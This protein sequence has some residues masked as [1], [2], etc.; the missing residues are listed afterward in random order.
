[1]KTSAALHPAIEPLESRIA[2]ATFLV[3]SLA[4]GTPTKDGLLT[5]REAIL[6]ATTNLPSGDAKAGGF[7]LDTITFSPSLRGGEIQ[8]LSSLLIDG[9]GRLN[10]VGPGLTDESITLRGDGAQRVMEITAATTGVAL[11]HLAIT[12]GLAASGGGILTNAE[13]LL[14]NVLISGNT[15]TSS[16]GGIAGI[17]SNADL[18]VKNSRL[19]NNT[20]DGTGGGG[21][22]LLSGSGASLD[23]QGTLISGN[24]S[25]EGAGIRALA[26]TSATISG[27]K[28]VGNFGTLSG[29]GA[30]IYNSGT[31]LIS[32]TTISG[33]IGEGGLF[34]GGG[35]YNT[36]TLTITGSTISD[37]LSQGSGGGIRNGGGTLAI[38]NSTIAGNTSLGSTGGGLRLADGDITIINSTI[39]GNLDAASA[40]GNSAGGIAADAGVDSL[41]IHNS[42]IAGNLATGGNPADIRGAV[43]AGVFNFIGIGTAE[44]TGITNGANGNQIGTSGTPLKAKLGPLQDNGGPVFTM[45]PQPGSPVIDAGD[46]FFANAPSGAQLTSDQRG[47]GFTRYHD[48]D[49]DNFSTVDIGAAEYAPAPTANDATT[50]TFTQSSGGIVT[51]TLTGGGAFDLWRTGDGINQIAIHGATAKSAFTLKTSTASGVTVQAIHSDAGLKSITLGKGTDLAHSIGVEGALGTL[52]LDQTFSGGVIRTGGTAKNVMKLTTNGDFD[53]ALDTTSSVAPITMPKFA[54]QGSIRAAS[55]GAITAKTFNGATMDDPLDIGDDDAFDLIATTGGIGKLSATNG[56][57]SDY[58]IRTRGALAGLSVVSKGANNVTALDEI[59]ITAGQI[60]KITIALTSAADGGNSFLSGITKSGITTTNGPIAGI[61]IALN[62]LNSGTKGAGGIGNFGILAAAGIGP[63]TIAAPKAPGE[64]DIGSGSIT[65]G[66]ALRG[67]ENL[68]TAAAQ[69]AALKT[70]GLAGIKISGEI[71]AMDIR[72]AGN[73]GPIFAATEIRNAEILAGANLGNDGSIGGTG[74]AADVFLRPASIASITTKGVIKES[75]I[76]AGIAAVNGTL[77]DADDV[78]GLAGLT[79]TG[80]KIGPIKIGTAIPTVALNAAV[81]HTKTIQAATIAS[82]IVAGTALTPTA[83]GIVLDNGTTAA[84]DDTADILIRLR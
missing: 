82:I 22:I 65:A 44:L 51:A 15:A 61:S 24:T 41:T 36:G 11:S 20:A 19:I 42:I 50:F 56:N 14:E 29:D 59:G 67:W 23:L 72:V 37:N 77:G 6:A 48:G 8:L 3:N 25:K 52:V 30:G 54:F 35:I 74:L 79:T 9:G 58:S 27:S 71:G 1:M 12:G 80:S 18:T 40:A 78:A 47:P 57:I 64:G 43:T 4:D 34:F 55:I 5:L 13:L 10:I 76:S 69:L 16:G 73:I 63:I 7:L 83:A 60:G 46:F 84:M 62:H 32:G 17:G 31:M 70:Y 26:G 38:I 33:N 28:I 75:I 53:M 49:G 2:P 68:P 45:L 81:M 39:T 21:A 66:T